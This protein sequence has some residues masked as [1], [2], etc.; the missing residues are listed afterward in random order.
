MTNLASLSLYETQLEVPGD[1][2][3]IYG[4]VD[5]DGREAKQWQLSMSAPFAQAN[6]PNIAAFVLTSGF[7]LCR[8]F[9]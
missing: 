9:V 6:S 3:L 7:A 5:Y 4:D 1:A 8:F 2:P